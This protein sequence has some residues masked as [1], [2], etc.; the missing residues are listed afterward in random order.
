MVQSAELLLQEIPLARYIQ[1]A[2]LAD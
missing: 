2:H 1:K